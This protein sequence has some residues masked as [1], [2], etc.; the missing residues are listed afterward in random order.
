MTSLRVAQSYYPEHRDYPPPPLGWE[1]WQAE[2]QACGKGGGVESGV[3][4]G[5][6]RRRKAES[7][8]K[9]AKA[10]LGTETIIVTIC[11]NYDLPY[12]YLIDG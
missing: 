6:F 12:V 10:G 11:L 8:T 4:G 9:G 5:G 1:G 2:G 7:Y 3:G